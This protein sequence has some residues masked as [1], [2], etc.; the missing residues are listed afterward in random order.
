M[1]KLP[2]MIKFFKCAPVYRDGVYV[3]FWARYLQVAWKEI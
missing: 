1:L 2:L 3:R